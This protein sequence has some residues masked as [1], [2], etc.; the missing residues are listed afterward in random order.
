MSHPSVTLRM[1]DELKAILT[2]GA[3]VADVTLTEYIVRSALSQMSR[4]DGIDKEQLLR[5]YELAEEYFSAHARA[6][7]GSE[8]RAAS[9]SR[10]KN[11]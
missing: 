10:R 2:E 6:Q 1:P 9:I 3:R 7:R 8:A 5:G 4:T 11:G